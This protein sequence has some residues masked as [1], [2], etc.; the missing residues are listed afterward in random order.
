MAE[1]LPPQREVMRGF[2]RMLNGDMAR[3]NPEPVDE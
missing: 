1:P 2:F 3:V